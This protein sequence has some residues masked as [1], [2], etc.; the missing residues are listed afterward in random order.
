MQLLHV[1]AIADG[2]DDTYQH[3]DFHA[4]GNSDEYAGYR[5]RGCNSHADTANANQHARRGG[6]R[7]GCDANG[8]GSDFDF[9]IDTIGDDKAT[10]TATETL[11][12]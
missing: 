6:Y 4:Y 7:S 9:D 10:I 8:D 5:Y 1:D 11:I 2:D 3:S 12:P